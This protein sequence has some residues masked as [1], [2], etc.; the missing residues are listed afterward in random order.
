[1]QIVA[2]TS[3]WQHTPLT[4]DKYPYPRWDSN[5][6]S[7]QASGLCDK[8]IT[9]PEESY[10]LWCVVVCDLET[11]RMGA[12]YVY[13][14]SRLRVNCWWCTPHLKLATFSFYEVCMVNIKKWKARLMVGI[15][16]AWAASAFWHFQSSQ[17]SW[18]LKYSHWCCYYQSARYSYLMSKPITWFII[19]P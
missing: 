19:C 6:R 7:Q 5:P 9:C 15:C 4:T 14:I 18:D 8:L 1:M 10:R 12:P 11:S 17:R 13:D 3:T 2:E 16:T